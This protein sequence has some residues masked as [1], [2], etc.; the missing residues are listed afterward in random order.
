MKLLVAAITVFISVPSFAISFDNYYCRNQDSVTGTVLNLQ[1]NITVLVP[2]QGSITVLSTPISE[3]TAKIIMS[4]SPTSSFCTSENQSEQ[5]KGRI[6][7]SS[8]QD[9]VTLAITSLANGKEITQV[10]LCTKT[11]Y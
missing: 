1:G 7:F 2:A 8:P 5:L 9:A 4:C 11:S 10:T 3:G 6:V